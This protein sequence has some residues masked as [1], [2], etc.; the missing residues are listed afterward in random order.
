T[1]HMAAI[2]AP[3]GILA[4][5]STLVAAAGIGVGLGVVAFLI[6]GAVRGEPDP[7]AIRFSERVFAK[8]PT[9]SFI[10]ADEQI[11]RREIRRYGTLDHTD[12]DA[13]LIMTMPPLGRSLTRDFDQEFGEL[14]PL[15]NAKAVLT[16][17][18]DFATRFGGY[19]AV[20]FN[21]DL[22]VRWKQCFAFVSR[23]ESP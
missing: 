12:M 4:R 1:R 15:R 18:F 8:L 10:A 13:T 17:A 2:T 9:Q 11:G 14:A 6:L 22:E 23:F 16:G 20:E 19:R 21:L 5:R 7:A 3:G